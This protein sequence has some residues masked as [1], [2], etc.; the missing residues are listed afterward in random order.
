MKKKIIT[1][2]GARP[3]II[4]ASA[5]SRAIEKKFSDELEEILVHTGQH[6]DD[7]MSQVFFEELG[8]PKPKYNL[9][10]GSGSHGVQTAK[11]IEGLEQIFLNNLFSPYSLYQNMKC[12]A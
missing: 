8:I 10:V 5:L 9:S 11:M 3:Q 4:K 1:I 2:I 7:N 6:Y 12:I